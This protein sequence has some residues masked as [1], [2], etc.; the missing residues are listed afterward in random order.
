MQKRPVT[1][2]PTLLKTY[3]RLFA[4]EIYLCDQY[5]FSYFNFMCLPLS[6]LRR[7]ILKV[8]GNKKGAGVIFCRLSHAQA[9]AL[10]LY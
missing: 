9:F 1:P 4:A 6:L 7:F 3:K 2:T 10:P 8:Y 5:V